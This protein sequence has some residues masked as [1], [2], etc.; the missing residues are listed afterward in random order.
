[1]NAFYDVVIAG[2]GPAGAA[3]A[4]HLARSGV[5]VLLADTGSCRQ[6]ERGESLPADALH[7]LSTLGCGN[8]FSVDRHPRLQT[9]C[10]L[11]GSDTPQF[12]DS[13]TNPLGS[14]WIL[15]RDRFGATLLDEA[16]RAGVAVHR[17]TRVVGVCP[18]TESWTVRFRDST[19][20]SSLSCRFLV[21]ATGQMATLARE[22]GA[23]RIY[24]DRLV[25]VSALIP[26][27]SEST[28]HISTIESFRHGW[29]YTAPLPAGWRVVTLFS[30]SDLVRAHG[31]ATPRTWLRLL[32]ESSLGLK[33]LCPDHT[34]PALTV[35]SAATQF[36]ECGGIRWLSVGDAASSWDPLSSA[37]ITMGLRM[38]IEASRAIQASL[39][40][41]PDS[42]R[43]YIH[44][45]RSRMRWYLDEKANQYAVEERWSE[46][47]FWKRRRN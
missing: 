16:E 22:L 34:E 15:D 27:S 39:A 44:S 19:G 17:Q 26:A 21:D 46:E 2:G 38:G 11:W 45:I 29:W 24:F 23:R 8:S 32:L 41:D 9:M 33:F 18:S 40:G 14:G 6:F 35:C 25:A 4:I 10:S 30:D 28:A 13:F 12:R 5:S 43:C 47:P 1:M 20:G 31:F 37:G 7:E 42:V 3:A 36:V